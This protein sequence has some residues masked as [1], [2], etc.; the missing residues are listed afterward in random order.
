V[1][2]KFLAAQVMT[3]RNRATGKVKPATAEAA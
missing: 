1:P 2:L 3:E